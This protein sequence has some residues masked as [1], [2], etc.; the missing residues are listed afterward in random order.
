MDSK[1]TVEELKQIANKFRNDRNWAQFHDP[2]E[3]ALVLSIEVGELLEHFRFRNKEEVQ[4]QVNSPKVRAEIEKEL[5]DIQYLVSLLAI[6]MNMDLT[7]ACQTKFGPGGEA[8][9]KYPIELSSG[10]N[11]KYKEYEN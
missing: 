7:K 11:K 9:L 5:A 3:L 2:K 4:S 6:E 8:S 10:K 1:T